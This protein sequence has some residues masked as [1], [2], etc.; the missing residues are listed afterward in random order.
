MAT[1]IDSYSETNKDSSEPL[2]GGA[3]YFAF[4]NSFT[5]LNDGNNYNIT[6]AKFYLAKTGSPSGNMTARL[7]AHSGTYGTSSKPTGSVLGTSDAINASTLTGTFTLTEFTFTGAQQYTM[8][9]NT[10][11]C[12]QIFF[13]TGSSG[14]VVDVGE[15]GSSPT[16]GGNYFAEA[17]E[18]TWASYNGIDVPFY[19]YGEVG[20]AA[21]A[22]P[23]VK[24]RRIISH[25]R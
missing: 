2:Q 23:A 7:Y 15:D 3:G 9:A 24:R 19:V 12:I 22:A 6:S 4:G 16:H 10:Q 25:R 14:N 11:Y 18:G 17:P 5:T 20:A 8:T 1:L 21:A 13:S